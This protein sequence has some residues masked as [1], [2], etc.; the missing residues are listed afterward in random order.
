MLFNNELLPKIKMKQSP[1]HTQIIK[2]PFSK[3]NFL[4][5]LKLKI[6]HIYLILFLS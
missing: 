3:C 5:N 6:V 2:R 4:A 1:E